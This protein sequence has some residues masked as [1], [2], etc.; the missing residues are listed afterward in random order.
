MLKKVLT[1]YFSSDILISRKEEIVM[2]KEEIDPQVKLEIAFYNFTEA[3]KE[4]VD[5]L[6]EKS[7]GDK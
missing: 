7:K 2:K 5:K 6:K 1:L 3:I 4:S